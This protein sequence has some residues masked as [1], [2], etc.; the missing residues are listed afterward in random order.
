MTL[1]VAWWIWVCERHFSW[2][3][4]FPSNE[5]ARRECRIPEYDDSLDYSKYGS[6]K[7]L[8]D[9]LPYDTICVMKK[10]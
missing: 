3:K 8:N 1:F 5:A 10:R 4:R 9:M 2:A 7:Y 6:M